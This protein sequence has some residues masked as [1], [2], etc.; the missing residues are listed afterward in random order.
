MRPLLLERRCL[1]PGKVAAFLFVLCYLGVSSLHNC[2]VAQQ[3]PSSQ[4][5][6]EIVSRIEPVYPEIAR[7][8]QLK[9]SVRLQVKVA[10]AGNV[11]SVQVLG[12]PPIFAKAS[13]QAIE[14]WRWERASGDTEELVQLTFKNP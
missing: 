12:G 6:R 10:A 3:N 11:T 2:S 7:R 14:K 4:S 1:N 8:V 13:V 5:K 9:G